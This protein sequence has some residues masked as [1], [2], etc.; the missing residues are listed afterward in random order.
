MHQ[1]TGMPSRR[2]RIIASL[3]PLELRP[4]SA[5]EMRET[6]VSPKEIL[7]EAYGVDPQKPM[8]IQQS[9]K[10]VKDAQLPGFCVVG[11]CHKFGPSQDELR[12]I[13]PRVMLQLMDFPVD[14]F[15]WLPGMSESKKH[16]TIRLLLNMFL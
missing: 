6:F 3:R 9:M 8:V 15:K 7:C 5:R 13:S 16:S 11:G 10:H 2:K 4:L 12:V 1:Y 14:E